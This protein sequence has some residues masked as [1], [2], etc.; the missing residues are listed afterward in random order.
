MALLQSEPIL[1]PGFDTFFAMGFGTGNDGA[2]D[3]DGAS[4]IL[5]LVPSGGVYTL[6]RDI[7]PTSMV[8]RSGV[9][10][11]C[12]GFVPY[13][14]GR[15][16]IDSGGVLCCKANNAVGSIA[17]ATLSAIGSLSTTAAAGGT[18][19][20]TTGAGAGGAG[21]G[22][23]NITGRGS[24]AG[25]AANAQAG[26]NGNTTVAPTAANGSPYEFGAFLRK[27]LMGTNTFNG[28]GGGGAGGCD[29]SLGG[30]GDSGGG[31]SGCPVLMFA[32]RELA[33]SGVIHADG[34]NGGN[35][36][37]TGNGVAG[38][39]GGGSPGAIIAVVGRVLL[40]GTIRAVAGVG[41]TGFGTGSVSGANG[42]GTGTLYKF[43]GNT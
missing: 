1:K 6:T 14:M 38:G 42:T 40:E 20:N 28:S 35:A 37:G 4:T 32:C 17:G 23:N 15:L 36:I 25:G 24:G 18:G 7:F 13:V 12:Q 21:A 11:R 31:G 43:Y 30:T 9:E 41:G 34:G 19:R 5:T 22:S 39:G 2:V 26:G 27:R 16:T 29:L 8:I 33:N 10:V 3:F